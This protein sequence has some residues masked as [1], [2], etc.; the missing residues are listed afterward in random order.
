MHLQRSTG[1][2]HSEITHSLSVRS[3]VTASMVQL[4]SKIFSGS[5]QHGEPKDLHEALKVC[6]K[7]NNLIKYFQK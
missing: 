4:G 3:E 2:C 1:Q 5:I 6:E 7:A